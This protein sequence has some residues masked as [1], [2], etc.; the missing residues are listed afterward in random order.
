MGFGIYITFFYLLIPLTMIIM[1][2]IFIKRPPKEIN[3]VLGYRTSMS[4]KNLDTWKFAHNYS[5]WLYFKLGLI[6]F[7][8]S[9]IV[10]LAIIKKSGGFIGNIISIIP[11]EVALR[12]NFDKY[13]NRKNRKKV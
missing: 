11:T 4:K 2:I 1:R 10:I 9:I 13:G 8:I 12:K 5:G 6:M 7:I 3:G